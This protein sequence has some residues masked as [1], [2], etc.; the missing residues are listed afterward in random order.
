M[1]KIVDQCFRAHGITD[2]AQMLDKIKT[3]GFKYSTKRRHHRIRGAISLF[4]RQKDDTAGRSRE[5]GRQV[6]LSA[7]TA[8]ARCRENERYHERHQGLG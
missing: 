4:R 1:G 5:E 8:A 6:R 7:P 2:T 3:L